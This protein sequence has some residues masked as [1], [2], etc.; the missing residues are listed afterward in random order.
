MTGSE[1]TGSVDKLPSR[2]P[3]V[4]GTIGVILG[5]LMFIDKIDDLLLIQFL[6]SEEKWSAMVGPELAEFIVGVIPPVSWMVSSGLI[7]MALAILLIV[8]SVRLRRRRQSGI[9]LC[10]TWSW[11]AIA[12][13]GIEM[14]RAFWWFRIHGDEVG[15]FAS[16]GWEGIAYFSVAVAFLVLLAY[17][18]FLL[19]WLSRHPVV[20][21]G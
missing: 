17:P 7:G 19:V 18:V 11:L 20:S 5:V 14:A 12:W 6:R 15:R 8:G 9:A 3:G 21:D 2:W 10:R 4:V 16:S 13:V 1:G